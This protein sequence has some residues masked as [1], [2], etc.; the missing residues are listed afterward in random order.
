[1]HYLRIIIITCVTFVLFLIEALFH[2]NIGKNDY[3]KEIKM[4][5]T[6]PTFK[7]FAC[8]V[9]VLAFFSLLNGLI[10]Q[11]IMKKIT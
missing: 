7:E 3:D 5:I 10:S 8:I 2:F 1:M 4:K 9:G 11:F 6:M